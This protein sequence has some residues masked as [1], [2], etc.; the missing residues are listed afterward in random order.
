MPGSGGGGQQRRT[1]G[2]GGGGGGVDRGTP[3]TLSLLLIA[4][5]GVVSGR[6]PPPSTHHVWV[7]GR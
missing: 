5:S 6:H 2:R 1:G 7:R 3:L 4:V